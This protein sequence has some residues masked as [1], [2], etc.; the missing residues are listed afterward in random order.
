MALLQT[1]DTVK[2][3]LGEGT[4]IFYNLAIIAL[5]GGTAASL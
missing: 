3:E 1:C 4:F 2:L 5:L